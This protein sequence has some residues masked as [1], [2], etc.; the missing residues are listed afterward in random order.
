MLI[1]DIKKRVMDAMKA[2]NTVEKEILKV[3]LGEAQ[4]NAARSEGSDDDNAVLAVVKKLVKSNEET[5]GASDDA[6]QRETLEKELEILRSLM[7]KTLSQTEVVEALGPVHE[8]IKSAN[9]DGQATG[10][11]MKHLA[12]RPAAKQSGAAV[13]GKTVSLAVKQ[14]R[15]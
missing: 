8:A 10:V 1:D 4:T 12:A 6:E 9:N 7:P 15:S 13:D 11:A 14:I 2:R 5:L 3:V